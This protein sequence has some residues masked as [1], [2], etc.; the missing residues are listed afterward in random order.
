MVTLEFHSTERSG[1]ESTMQV[2]KNTENEI[3]LI[4]EIDEMCWGSICLDK[5]TAIKF[6]KELRKQISYL[7]DK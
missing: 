7:E 3:Y 1:I 5:E 6:S 4:V 2:Y